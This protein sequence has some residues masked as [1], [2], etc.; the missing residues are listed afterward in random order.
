MEKYYIDSKWDEKKGKEVCW[1]YKR[2]EVPHFA[3]FYDKDKAIE[4]IGLLNKGN[5]SNNY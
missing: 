1:I 3:T 5:I 4:Y 2:G